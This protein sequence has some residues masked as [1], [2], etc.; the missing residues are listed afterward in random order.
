MDREKLVADCMN[1]IVASN[2][3]GAATSSDWMATVNE[4][5][6]QSSDSEDESDNESVDEF[7]QIAN[8]DNPTVLVDVVQ[9]VEKSHS[10]VIHDCPDVE[11][12]KVEQFRYVG[13]VFI[14][15]LITIVQWLDVLATSADMF[16]I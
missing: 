3:K 4:Y 10:V 6:V 7:D 11:R 9:A 14:T 2:L 1:L 12:L 8:D 16:L 13:V 15:M 5:F